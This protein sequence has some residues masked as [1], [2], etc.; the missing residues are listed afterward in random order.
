MKNKILLLSLSFLFLFNCSVIDELTKFDMD[1][2]TNYTLNPVPI[3]NFPVSLNTPDIETESESTFEN[4]NTKKDLI[5]SIKLKS[6]TIKISSPETG[7]FNFLKNVRIAIS[8]ENVEET[9][10][11]YLTDIPNDNSNSID[12]DIIDKELKAY[13]KEDT[14]KLR[15]TAVADE[16]TTEV[17]EVDFF[18]IFAVDAKILGI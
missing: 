10:V 3:V 1:Y 8:S 14:F 13:L 4:N 16:T 18:A 2:E 5:E 12:L 6:L 15:V 7:N 9:E 11:A 17:Y